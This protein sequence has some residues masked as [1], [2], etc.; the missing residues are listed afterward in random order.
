VADRDEQ[1]KLAELRAGELEKCRTESS[2]EGRAA[3]PERGGTPR[4]PST[5]GSAAVSPGSATPPPPPS[6]SSSPPVPIPAQPAPATP[7]E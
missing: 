4:P 2:P 5:P 1:K 6:P 7:S 3:Q